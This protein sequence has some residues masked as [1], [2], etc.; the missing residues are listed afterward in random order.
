MCRINI[1]R[2]VHI[3]ILLLFLLHLAL[4][5]ILHTS[6]QIHLFLFAFHY[7][8]RPTRNRRIP[9]I[10]FRSRFIRLSPLQLTQQRKRRELS[11]PLASPPTASSHHLP[12]LAFFLA[13]FI[14]LALQVA[15]V[16]H[17]VVHGLIAG[18]S[19]WT[20]VDTRYWEEHRRRRYSDMV[21]GIVT[22]SRRKC[23]LYSEHI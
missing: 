22:A 21:P 12:Q 16:V 23:A 19:Q 10:V 2:N 13:Q 17:P 15:V 14:H 11:L 6:I 4:I 9:F 1:L 8:R 7:R 20:R 3:Q 18:I 5:R